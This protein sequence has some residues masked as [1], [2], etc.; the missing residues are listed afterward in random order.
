MII[1]SHQV[2]PEG[3]EYTHDGKVLTVFSASNYCGGSN[4]GAVIRW[5][6]HQWRRRPFHLCLSLQGLQWRGTLVDLLQNPSRRDGAVEF[7]QEVRVNEATRSMDRGRGCSLEWLSSKILLIF[8]WR[9]RSWPTK[10][11]CWKNSKEPIRRRQ[12]CPEDS[13]LPSM[14]LSLLLD[15][16]PATVWSNIM[17]TV[18]QLDLPWLTLRAKLVEEDTQGVLYRTMFD[19]YALDNSKVQM[20]GQERER[21]SSNPPS[22]LRLL[23][24]SRD[25]GG[26]VHVERHADGSLQSDRLQSFWFVSFPRSSRRNIPRC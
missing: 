3:Y 14:F 13:L 26:S 17:A 12:V 11:L 5:S 4:W 22:L 1:R 2:K 18:L 15:H 8:P 10:V 9:K 16:L 6:V 23:V 20:V 25:H 7:Q 24:R 19:A 21:E